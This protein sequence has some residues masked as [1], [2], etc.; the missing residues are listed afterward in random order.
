MAGANKE[1]VKTVIEMPRWAWRK[2]NH[3]G[4][5]RNVNLPVV[6]QDIL[7]EDLKKRKVK[8]D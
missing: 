2:A 6:Y 1:T 4:T 5:E 3:I 7:I 8:V